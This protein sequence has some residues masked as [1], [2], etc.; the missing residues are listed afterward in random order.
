MANIVIPYP[1]E[2]AELLKEEAKKQDRTFSGYMQSLIKNH[3]KEEEK[4]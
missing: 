3:I 4:K 2:E 1:E